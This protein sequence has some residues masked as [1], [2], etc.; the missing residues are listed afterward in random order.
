WL[1]QQLAHHG[2]A[3]SPVQVLMDLERTKAEINGTDLKLVQLGEVSYSPTGLGLLERLTRL[4]LEVSELRGKL[5]SNSPYKPDF[6]W[7]HGWFHVYDSNLVIHD[8]MYPFSD[9]VR[10]DPDY[11]DIDRYGGIQKL[12]SERVVISPD[13]SSLAILMGDLFIGMMSALV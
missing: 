10:F 5:A 13:R 3:T 6:S 12:I 4:E 9:I 11:Y 1:E 7:I 2:F 8:K